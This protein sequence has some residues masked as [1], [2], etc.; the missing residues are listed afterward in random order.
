MHFT[1]YKQRKY[2]PVNSRPTGLSHTRKN[3]LHSAEQH[4][5]H[6]ETDTGL[7]NN[8]NGKLIWKNQLDVTGID[9]HSH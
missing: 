1:S 8:N 3:L 5:L 9:V 2:N 7:A 6:K 4:Y